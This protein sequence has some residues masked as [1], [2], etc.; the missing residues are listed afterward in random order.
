MSEQQPNECTC[1]HRFGRLVEVH[2]YDGLWQMLELDGL[3]YYGLEA[4]CPECGRRFLF[5]RARGRG[6]D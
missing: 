1:G 4:L 2:C 6:K 5:K 3:R